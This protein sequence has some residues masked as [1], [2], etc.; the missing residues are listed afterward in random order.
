ML[1]FAVLEYRTYKTDTQLRTFTMRFVL[2]FLSLFPSCVSFADL[3]ACDPWSYHV[4]EEDRSRPPLGWR[5]DGIPPRLVQ[6]FLYMRDDAD[7]NHYAHPVIQGHL[8][9][10]SFVHMSP[11]E[12]VT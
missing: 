8:L 9:I 6:T 4:T 11:K 1:A 7:D 12:T 2:Q 10:Q 3:L 5:D